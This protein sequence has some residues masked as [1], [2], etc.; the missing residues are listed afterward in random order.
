[1]PSYAQVEIRKPCL[2]DANSR[3]RKWEGKSNNHGQVKTVEGIRLCTGP[4]FVELLCTAEL[5]VIGDYY[6]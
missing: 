5:M 2:I 1:M 3:D 6:K 4:H